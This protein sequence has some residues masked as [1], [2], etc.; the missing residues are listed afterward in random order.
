MAQTDSKIRSQLIPLAGMSLVLPNTCIAEV[1]GYRE[2]QPVD[3]TPDWL[4][5]F[6]DWRGVRIPLISFEAANGGSPAK[7]NRRSRIVV[8]NGIGGDEKLSFF[9]LV[10]QGIPRLMQLDT[11]TISTLAQ[12]ENIHPLALQHTL[13]LEQEAVIPDQDKLERMIKQQG[14]SAALLTA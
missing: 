14:L 7:A 1:I 12:P 11:T 13:V 4:L 8:L 5:G 2:P 6:V 10:A 9:A 3:G